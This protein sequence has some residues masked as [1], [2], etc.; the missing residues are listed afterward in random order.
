MEVITNLGASDHMQRTPAATYLINHIRHI[1][2][3][4]S[5]PPSE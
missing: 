3:R 5:R 1:E 2:Q 4:D